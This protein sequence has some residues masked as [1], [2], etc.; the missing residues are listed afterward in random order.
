MKTHNDHSIDTGTPFSAD[1]TASLTQDFYRDGF[2]LIPGILT[3]AE[4]IAL[5]SAVDRFF[6]D[7]SNNASDN[8]YGDFIGVRLFERDPIFEDMLT[9][10]PIIGMM[11]HIL[12]ADCHLV[13]QNVVRNKPGVAIDNFHVDDHIEVPLPDDIPRHDARIT[14]PVCML[15]VQI[16]LTDVP[17]IEYGPSE[18]VPGSHYSGRNPND[19]KNP[20]F[21]GIKP[22]PVLGHAGDIYLHNGQC[23]HR[24]APNTSDRVRYL[25]Q[26]AYGRRWVSQRFYP[27]VNYQFPPGVL[28]RADERRKRV[29]GIHPKGAYG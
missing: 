20:V 12:G 5:K 9:K 11:E 28:E 3:P 27:F 1:R 22:V 8:L 29:L 16:L 6:A 14:L 23:W 17:S 26:M 13:A 15:T 18:Y 24:G 7:P 10:E 2:V 21:E 25:L 19:A 4:V